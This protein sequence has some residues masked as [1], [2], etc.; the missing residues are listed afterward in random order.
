MRTLIVDHEPCVRET[1]RNLCESDH[2]IDEVSEAE[3]G[4]TAIKMI[5]ARR[6]DLLLLDVELSDM[7][8]FDVLRS[9][10]DARRPPVI[11]VTAHE[12]H[13]VEAFRIGA[14]DY[15]TKPVNAD[16]F[17]TAI[18][19]VHERRK[20][21]PTDVQ[22]LIAAN[23]PRRSSPV[24]LIGE[25]SHRMYFLAVDEVDYIESCGNYVLI[26]VGTQKYIRRDTLKRLAVELRDAEF[27]WIGRSTL[28]NLARVAFAERLDHGALAF[29][30]KSGAR[31]ISRARVRL[32]VP[33][34]RH[35]AI[36]AE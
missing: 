34:E 13:A 17:A 33:R 24:R 36:S 14:I 28:V 30:L 23:S 2:S 5:R 29:T 12:Q 11:M 27:E 21:E 1:L 9:L 18:K 32:E 15:L 31:L 3:S 20:S 25:N 19:R 22:G 10:N 7:T 35:R 8:G 26:H 4:V 6:P 16:R